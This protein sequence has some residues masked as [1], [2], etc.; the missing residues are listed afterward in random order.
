MRPAELVGLGRI[1]RPYRL[2]V[3]LRSKVLSNDR[4][5]QITF[6]RRCAAGYLAKSCLMSPNGAGTGRKYDERTTSSEQTLGTTFKAS[7]GHFLSAV[8]RLNNFYGEKNKFSA[9]FFGLLRIILGN[10]QQKTRRGN[11]PGQGK[12]RGNKQK[13][14]GFN[15]NGTRQRANRQAGSKRAMGADRGDE[16]EYGI[17]CGASCLLLG[18]TV[19]R[20][21]TH[22]KQRCG[23]SMPSTPTKTLPKVPRYRFDSSWPN[24]EGNRQSIPL[25]CGILR[26]FPYILA[27]YSLFIPLPN[28]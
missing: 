23:P 6:G 20:L 5:E 8:V 16:G 14:G 17:I 10:M 19:R 25:Q 26:A 15:A 24:L 1:Y 7:T 2:L 21:F 27:T 28:P 22:H 12:L 4:G 11:R 13:V 9:A 3:P 18:R